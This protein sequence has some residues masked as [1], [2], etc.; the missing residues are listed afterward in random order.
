MPNKFSRIK[1]TKLFF[2]KASI[3][4]IIQDIRQLNWMR[5]V[6]LDK[7]KLS[8][9]SIDRMKT[10]R[11][12][13]GQNIPGEGRHTWQNIGNGAHRRYILGEWRKGKR[14]TRGPNFP[15]IALITATDVSSPYPELAPLSSKLGQG[16]PHLLVRN[17]RYKGIRAVISHSDK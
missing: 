2:N 12:S 3:S 15:S 17:T 10:V 13:A 1:F 8:I 9:E 7:D 11:Y 14:E 4:E 16:H 6:S 5:S